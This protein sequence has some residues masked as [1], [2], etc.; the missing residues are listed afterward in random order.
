MAEGGR[1]RNPLRRR[2]TSAL[3]ARLQLALDLP[4]PSC[5]YRLRRGYGVPKRTHF[6]PF[7]EVLQ[8]IR[9]DITRK[10]GFAALKRVKRRGRHAPL[11]R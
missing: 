8:E 3:Q 1:V 4:V 9:R 11:R 7:K 5:H 6:R 10:V 2:F